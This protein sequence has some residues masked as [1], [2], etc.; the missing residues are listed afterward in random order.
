MDKKIK[1][2]VT[3]DVKEFI[4]GCFNIRYDGFDAERRIFCSYPDIK[5]EFELVEVPPLI[6]EDIESFGWKDTK[7]R[8]MSEYSGWLFKMPHPEHKEH[9]CWLRYWCNN[10]RARI[11]GIVG[12]V[13]DGKI[14]D[15]SE[16]S[17]VLQWTG[18]LKN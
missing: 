16:L 18:I 11:D 5:D 8:G 15:K 7:D 4:L 2:I 17:K 13:F 9:D 1:M 14:N 10:N 12:V 6:K 3:E